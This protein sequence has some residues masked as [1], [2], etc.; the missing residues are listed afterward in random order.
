MSI[1]GLKM[2]LLEL[3]DDDKKVKKLR[4]KGLPKDWEDIKHV[5]YYQGI[6]YVLKVICSKLI[7]RYH[8]NLLA[9]HLGIEKICELITRKYY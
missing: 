1:G 4:L 2:R 7:N 6:P 8:N 3:Q 9:G 5:F